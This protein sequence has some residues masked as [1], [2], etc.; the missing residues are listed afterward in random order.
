MDY[1]AL[2]GGDGGLSAVD[3]SEFVEEMADVD[4]GGL[5]GDVEAVCD[6][7]IAET[8]GDETENIELAIGEF[9]PDM[10]SERRPQITGGR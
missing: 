6:F 4:F 10:R 5:L 3:D 9:E 7:A 2:N 8:F 1:A